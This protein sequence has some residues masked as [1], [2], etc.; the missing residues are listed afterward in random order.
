[1]NADEGGSHALRMDAVRPI[2]VGRARGLSLSIEVIE[3]SDVQ[4]RGLVRRIHLPAPGREGQPRSI[5]GETREQ[6]GGSEGGLPPGRGH[7]YRRP[8]LSS[9]RQWKTVSRSS[10]RRQR[11]SPSAPV[12]KKHQRICVHLRFECGSTCICGL[13][14]IHVHLRLR[15][16]GMALVRHDVER[17]AALARLELTG[18]ERI[19]SRGGSATSRA[20]RLWFGS[21]G[22]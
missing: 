10:V 2:R 17:I 19:S 13:I 1:M 12:S 14:W 11:N 8:S 16:G 6:P 21:S 7:P 9:T 15:I 20:M 18:E 22:G 4:T 3:H 5:R